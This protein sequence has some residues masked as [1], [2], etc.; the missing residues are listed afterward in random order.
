MTPFAQCPICKAKFPLLT[1][2]DWDEW[3]AHLVEEKRAMFDAM[4]NR[5]SK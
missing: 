2:D 4:M 1:Q 5:S 3:F